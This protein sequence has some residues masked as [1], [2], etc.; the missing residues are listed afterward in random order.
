MYFACRFD[1]ISLFDKLWEHVQGDATCNAGMMDI[2][3]L[4]AF[5]CT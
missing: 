2:Q 1:I 4:H 3:M 5:W